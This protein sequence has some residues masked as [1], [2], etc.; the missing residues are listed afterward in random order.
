M[1][2]GQPR[3]PPAAPS[4]PPRS[5]W[6]LIALIALGTLIGGVVLGL[7]VVKRIETGTWKMLDH[8]DYVKVRERLVSAP[9]PSA[10]RII[11]LAREPL[12]LSPGDDDAAAR[13][14]SVVAAQGS[15]TVKVPGWKG[16]TKA[17]NQVV[18]CVRG[19][20]GPFDVE[21]TDRPPT[22]PDHVLVVVSGRPTDIGVKNPRIGGLAPFNGDV[23]PRAVVF[24]FAQQL[25]H[26]PRTVCE[27]IG[28]EVAHAYGLDHAYL[29]K[30]VM[31][32]LKPCGAKT[33]VDQDVSCGEGKKRPCVGGGATQNSFRRLMAVLGPRAP[34]PT[35]AGPPRPVAAE[36]P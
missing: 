1:S 16:S 22:S 19:L 25:G 3:R 17:W 7:F 23:I 21:V 34:R 36:T 11:Y 27:T 9:P 18:T 4:P 5:R 2:R 13:R 30:D 14:S 32:Y 10:S 29:C 15:A 8:G 33:F 24:A 20:F 35:A 6:W 26:Q 28:M 31:T 12:T